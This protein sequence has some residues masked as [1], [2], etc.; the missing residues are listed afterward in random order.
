VILYLENRNSFRITGIWPLARRINRLNPISFKVLN[1]IRGGFNISLAIPLKTI[2]EV[3]N[4]KIV[5]YILDR[6]RL[7]QWW[8]P[9]MVLNA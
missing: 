7:Q 6:Y 1:I 9:A 3:L 5:G 4:F 2:K 8:V